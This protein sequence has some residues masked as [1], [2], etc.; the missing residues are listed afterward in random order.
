M[1]GM[2]LNSPAFSSSEF[3]RTQL[4]LSSTLIMNRTHDSGEPPGGYP[5]GSGDAEFSLVMPERLSARSPLRCSCLVNNFNYQDYVVE[6][7]DSALAQTR[8][9]DEIIVVDDGSTDRSLEI[10]RRRFLGEP[11]VRIIAKNNGGQLSCFNVGFLESTGDVLFFLDADD[12]YKPDYVAEAVRFFNDHPDC[13]LLFCDY[14]I[15]G[16]ERAEMQW[17]ERSQLLGYSLIH[18]LC[19]RSWT[20]A[21]TSCLAV[22]RSFAEQLLPLPLEA[23]WRIRADDCL[24]FGAS[25]LCAR[26]GY[27]HDSLVEYR[28]HGKNNHH[29]A[30]T[31][32]SA[33]F[34]HGVA[35]QRLF[36]W[37]MHNARLGRDELMELTHRE[38]RTHADPTY[39]LFRDYMKLVWR[40]NLTWSKWLKAMLNM[41]GHYLRNR[42]RVW[43][44]GSVGSS[45]M[46][47][48]RANRRADQYSLPRSDVAA[49][50]P[51]PVPHRPPSGAAKRDAA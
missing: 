22:R 11:R 31:D 40:S 45:P 17:G 9:L 47:P 44:A 7:V 51:H 8:P 37:L 41:C 25:L 19:R 35:V 30:K 10:I 33:D 46:T 15:F 23:D 6:A 42:R 14:S 48:H 4:P 29:H 26:K 2:Y 38:F 24:I 28:S 21:P 12:R 43:T 32:H 16:R 49:E 36:E 1:N 18:T 20:G 3:V 39:R 5:A 34:L 27:L 13:G 50:G